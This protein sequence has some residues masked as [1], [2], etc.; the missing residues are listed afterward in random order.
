MFL[1]IV[2]ACYFRKRV[3]VVS[4]SSF[5]CIP[6][7]KFLLWQFSGEVFDHTGRLNIFIPVPEVIPRVYSWRGSKDP[8][9][10]F[11]SIEYNLRWVIH[12]EAFAGHRVAGWRA[13]TCGQ[14]AKG[15]VR[16]AAEIQVITEEARRSGL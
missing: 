16:L 3:S 10:E 1:E 9:W 14:K 12:A 2:Q 11:L 4:R 13:K 15:N 6:S 5:E 8:G 7:A